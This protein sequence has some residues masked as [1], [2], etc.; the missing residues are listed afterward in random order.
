MKTFNITKKNRKY[1]AAT[2]ENRY[3]C[4]ILIDPN[5]ERLELGVQELEVEDIS[6]RTK[7]GTD[8]IFKLSAPANAQ[9]SAGICTLKT[10]M[11]NAKMVEIC[12]KLG[13]KWDGT[14]QSWVF[15]ALVEDKVEELDEKY[16]SA[17]VA[18]EIKV[19]ETFYEY[20]SAATIAGFTIARAYG[21]DSGAKIGDGIS[22]IEGKPGSGGSRK[23]WATVIKEGT[24]FRM[25]IPEGCIPDIE[26]HYFEVKK[27]G[28]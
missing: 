14:A 20:E 12:H 9:K 23:N 8:L 22:F 18:L 7:Y 26:T 16:N 6:V 5:S 4:K 19:I 28:E 10:P 1:F 27:L 3:D 15:S 21:R 24:V 11:Y 2:L 13:G 17:L 25:Q